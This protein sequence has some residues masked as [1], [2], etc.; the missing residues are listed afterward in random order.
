MNSLVCP[1]TKLN[2]PPPPKKRER[3]NLDFVSF[4]SP[5]AHAHANAQVILKA[6]SNLSPTDLPGAATPSSHCKMWLA[7]ASR[8]GDGTCF[9]VQYI[10]CWWIHCVCSVECPAVWRLSAGCGGERLCPLRNGAVWW[11]RG[12]WREPRWVWGDHAGCNDY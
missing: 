1:T 8:R 6:L 3:K 2:D 10:A 4:C 7:E 12:L 5:S 9:T 11:Q